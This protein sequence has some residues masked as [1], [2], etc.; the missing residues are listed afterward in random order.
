MRSCA[1]HILFIIVVFISCCV[2]KEDLEA[3]VLGDGIYFSTT[4][5]RY[6]GK[7]HLAY[8]MRILH[9]DSLALSFQ[10]PPERAGLGLL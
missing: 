3:G 1:E 10:L 8:Y 4:A 9:D 5:F 7:D 2:Y 6:R